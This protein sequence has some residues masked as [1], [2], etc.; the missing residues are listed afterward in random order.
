MGE[1][2]VTVLG[3]DTHI[4]GEM[5]FAGNA[6]LLGTF[7]GRIVTKGDLHVADSAACK[8]SLE[9]ARIIVDGTVEGDIVAHDRVELNATAQV[10]GNLTAHALVVSEGA[11]FVGHCKVGPEAIEEKK[12]TGAM[13]GAAASAAERR[14][15]ATSGVA[16]AA[17][18]TTPTVPTI[19]TRPTRPAM[20]AAER[21]TRA[22]TDLQNDPQW[23]QLASA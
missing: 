4:K 11:S 3:A 23:Q 17:P 10:T 18:M 12:A 2:N 13:N 6:R 22:A 8:A 19:Q 21:I 20:A 15:M 14:P 9:A 5:T 1:A 7:E 16:P